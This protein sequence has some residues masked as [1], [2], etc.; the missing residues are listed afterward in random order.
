MSIARLFALSFAAALLAITP[1]TGPAL[2]MQDA[3]A[4]GYR[5][6]IERPAAGGDR[7]QVQ[8]SVHHVMSVGQTLNGQE[9]GEDKT[10][11]QAEL[12]GIVEVL[13]V[14]DDGQVKSIAI[15]VQD[16]EGTLNQVTVP[17]DTE[18]RVL[19][20]VVD[21]EVVGSYE[22]AGKL[23]PEAVQVMDKLFAFTLSTDESSENEDEW[24]Y[25]DQPRQPGQSWAGNDELIAES[26]SNDEIVVT[27]EQIDSEFG[28]L[29]VTEFD[30]QPAMNVMMTINITGLDAPM[31][32]NQG[33]KIQEASGSMTI[34]GQLPLEPESKDGSLQMAMMM[35]MSAAIDL[36]DDQ[37]KA[38]ITLD[39]QS[40]AKATYR[41]VE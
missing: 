24:F 35:Q 11:I 38:V 21:G 23:S 32:T 8:T 14:D 2:A 4:E 16:Y 36:P 39:I 41:A 34:A 22:N 7:H 5:L 13:E 9:L 15:T 28:F 6:V 27:P 3:P 40:E 33:Y 26:L 29:E 37:G 31:L 25:L 1:T 18:A 10:D 12:T 17:V 30:Q 20:R 19:L